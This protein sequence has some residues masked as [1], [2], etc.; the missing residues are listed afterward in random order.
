MP[1]SHQRLP[2]VVIFCWAVLVTILSQVPHLLAFRAAGETRYLGTLAPWPEDLTYHLSFAEQARRGELL[3]EDKYNGNRIGTRLI[4]NSLFLALGRGARL[5]GLGVIEATVLAKLLLGFLLLL[6]AY[7]FATPY[8]RGPTQELLFLIL[9]PFGAGLGWLTA[10]HLVK[11]LDPVDLVFVE[12]PAFHGMVDD[13]IVPATSAALLFTL[14]LL[15]RALAQ[16]STRNAVACGLAALLLG[17]VHPHD[18][19]VTVYAVGVLVALGR[20]LVP[21]LRPD[22]A[23]TPRAYLT[24]LLWVVACSLPILLYDGYVLWR[25]P[26]FWHYVRLNDGFNPWA[27]ATGLGLPLGLAVVG[28]V[29]TLRANAAAWLLPVTWPAVAL[30]LLF[31][32]VPPCGQFF[33][34]HGVSIGLCLLAVSPLAWLWGRFARGVRGTGNA[35]ALSGLLAGGLVIVLVV[36]S[37]L[38]V[39]VD[40]R[41][42]SAAIRER[43]PDRFVPA[44]LAGCLSRLGAHGDPTSVLLAG[45]RASR[46]APLLAGVRVFAG[47]EEQTVDYERWRAE[48]LALLGHG[49]QQDPARFLK[50]HGVRFVLTGPEELSRPHLGKQLREAGLRKLWACGPYRVY[51]RTGP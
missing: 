25:E 6:S 19:L 30:T 38:T 33:L 4:F 8:L 7:R 43:S 13:L 46:L 16:P 15:D 28:A 21:R 34:L 27:V 41:R 3:F 22:P 40:A 23:A 2:R 36:G 9:A 35:G 49:P 26:L 47:Q 20:V 32:P 31:V 18:L 14:S 48:A 11:T 29:R 24:A 44:G 50:E 5:A 1:S 51:E 17:T 45:E 39:V 42:W 10:W 12:I 37:C